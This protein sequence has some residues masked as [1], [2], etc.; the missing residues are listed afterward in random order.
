MHII[1]YWDDDPVGIDE[2]IPYVDALYTEMQR[3]FP[4]K[5]VL[6]GETGWP[7]VG[8]PRGAIEP[9][10]VNQA[11]YI[12][13]FTALAAQHGIR[14]NL[15]E[16][17][18]QPWKRVPEGTVGGHWGLYDQERNEKFPWTGPVA[19]APQGRT[20]VF[21]ALAAALLGGG[22]GFARGGAARLRAAVA[23]AS[24][25]ALLVGIGAYQWHD[26]RLNN[27]TAVDW[28]AT[29]VIG[30]AGWMAFALAVRALLGGPQGRDPV[31]PR[32]LLLLLLGCACIRLGLVF[33]GR[34]R[35]FPF[36]LFLPG[37]MGITLTSATHRLERALY[38]LR[39]CANG[40]VL[41]ATWLV[42]AGASASTFS[43][44]LPLARLTSH[45]R[46]SS[47]RPK[48][49]ANPAISS[50]GVHPRGAVP[51]AAFPVGV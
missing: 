32:L 46:N 6:I 10:R 40:E 1:P 39:R 34:H 38:L 9:G 2:V 37:V 41:L 24:A 29:L 3:R 42:V 19:E 8:R 18:D 21:T 7:S 36:W 25:A 14:Y 49:T 50:Q 44:P 11:R 26:L 27:A 51:N 31:P 16:A 17:F 13:E 35:D 15:I 43:R 47:S 45:L 28:A 30:A 5:D 12:R 23:F 48:S 22:L 33:A 20:I 4:G